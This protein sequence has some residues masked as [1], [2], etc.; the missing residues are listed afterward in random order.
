[1]NTGHTLSI[2]LAGLGYGGMTYDNAYWILMNI[3]VHSVS[4]HTW[5]G[6]HRA[7]ELHLVHK[8]YDSDALLVVA[9]GVEGSAPLPPQP[10]LL[11][12]NTSS[13]KSLRKQMPPPTMPMPTNTHYVAPPP[14]EP[15][16]NP[17]LQ[18]F[19][20]MEPPPINM[21][22]QVPSNPANKFN[23]NNLLQGSLYYDYAGSLTAPPCA[24]TV[25]WL[26]R[27]DPIKASDRQI[28]YLRG[29][30][31]A[32]TAG[33]GNYRSL[34]PLMGR[35]V[36]M[37]QGIADT[38]PLQAIPDIN[39]DDMHK[40]IREERA[41]K[42]AKDAMTIA[43]TA[44]NYVKD[45]DTRLRNAAQAHANALAPH[46]E[47]FVTAGQG[48]AP[49]VAAAPAAAFAPLAPAVAV[50][51]RD[52]MEKTAQTMARTLADAA[53]KEIDDASVKINEQAREAAMM[54]AREAANIVGTGQGNVN[55]LANSVPALAPM[56]PAAGGTTQKPVIQ[57]VPR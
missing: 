37:R 49:V 13:S 48:I 7:V 45:L 32:I 2:D 39:L 42:W 36:T 40:N 56:M 3:N 44:T 51:G 47:P 12:V 8:R 46:M 10:M 31:S 24:E 14:I 4:E 25:T 5:N 50:M 9:I 26:V 22:V 19:L 43:R 18:V 29:V 15:N 28:F 54:A 6:A 27:K 35:F 34:M 23:L 21:K 16:F 57:I 20:A 53:S 33:M 52:E 30:I 38:K 55:T 17:D 11:E 41:M 1:M